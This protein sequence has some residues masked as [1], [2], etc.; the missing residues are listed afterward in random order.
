VAARPW[1]AEPLPAWREGQGGLFLPLKIPQERA[2]VVARRPG[3]PGGLPSH[4]ARAR[5]RPGESALAVCGKKVRRDKKG[6]AD[7][8]APPVSERKQ[9]KK[10]TPAGWVAVLRGLLGR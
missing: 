5:A 6:V 8:A 7:R 9:K 3:Q 4:R 10:G 2:R 1:P